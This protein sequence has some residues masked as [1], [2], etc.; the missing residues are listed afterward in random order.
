MFDGFFGFF[1]FYLGN[2]G[3][4]HIFVATKHKNTLFVLLL[5][6]DVKTGFIGSHSEF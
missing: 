1:A 6:P 3:K 2:I 5:F 4:K